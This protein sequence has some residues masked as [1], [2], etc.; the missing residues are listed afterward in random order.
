M[1][2]L[3]TVSI[4]LAVAT[5]CTSIRETPKYKLS[6]GEYLF[7]QRG[8]PNQRVFI[9]VGE[10]SIT[11]EPTKT[12]KVIPIVR[13]GEDEYFVQRSFDVDVLIAPFKY[14]PA[15]DNLPRQLNTSFNGNLFLGY[16]IDHFHLRFKKTP[17]GMQKQLVHRALSVGGFGGFG[18]T[19]ISPWTTNNL[20][21][22]E[23][24][25]FILTRGLGVLVGIN[26]LTVGGAIGFD[27]LT[28]RDKDTWI[29][30]NRPW[31]GLVVGLNLN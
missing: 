14:R 23:Y 21:Q 24:E 28:D 15:S 13:K 2:P 16:R 26:N 9:H 25:G 3:L 29:Y 8:Q 6:D 18:S 27:Y 30:Q 4:I 7:H 17:V 10:D 12:S 5:S 19:A 20:Q 11:L 1:R 22:D 31:L